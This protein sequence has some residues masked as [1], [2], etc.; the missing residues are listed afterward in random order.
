MDICP[1]NAFPAPYRLDA[2]R[3]ISYLTIELK[4]SIPLELRPLIGDRIYGC[5]DC[6]DACPWN[7]FARVSRETAFEMK[8]E[9]AAMRLRDYLGLDEEK[10]RALFR[11]SPIKRTKRRGLLRNVCVAL[12]NVGSTDDLPALKQ[13]A[14]DSE[15]LIAEHAAW[16]IDQIKERVSSRA[17]K[18]ARDLAL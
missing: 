9:V 6:L 14:T 2:R 12:G 17:A 15:P 11:H 10:F 18:V 4:G 8:P 13:A 5:D 7:R 3:C 16:A 1:T